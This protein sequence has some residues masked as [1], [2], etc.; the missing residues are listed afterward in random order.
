MSVKCIRE[1]TGKALLH[2]W[3]PEISGGKHTTGCPG[4]L[5]T[6]EVLDKT[7]GQTWDS[8]LDAN[9][10]LKTEKLV[11][12]PDQLIKRRGKA[13]LIAINKTYDEAK[14]W[15]MERMCKEQQ[16][17]TVTGQLT[18]FLIEPMV[19]HKQEQEH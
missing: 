3:L 5:V 17:E 7:S 10:W 9:P 16:V 12:K 11:A 2:K 4:V 15:V 1:H 19:P 13:G 6:P 8:I 14:A 18:H